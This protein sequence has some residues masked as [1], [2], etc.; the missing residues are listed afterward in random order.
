MNGH[1][2]I[3][4]ITILEFPL[5]KWEGPTKRPSSFCQGGKALGAANFILFLTKFHIVAKALGATNF[6]LFLT[7]L[8]I[9]VTKRGGGGVGGVLQIV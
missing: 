2:L 8:H 3:K 1:P 6:I 5:Y 9:L 7:K 4:K